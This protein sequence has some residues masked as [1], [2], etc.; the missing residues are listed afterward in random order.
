M[1]LCGLG[2]QSRA[3]ALRVRRIGR[4]AGAG[5]AIQFQPRNRRL[6]RSIGQASHRPGNIHAALAVG[7]QV[8]DSLHGFGG[9]AVCL[10]GWGGRGGLA[11]AIP[12]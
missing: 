6:L 5:E 2:Q 10:G 7:A 9:G 8:H 1:P 3:R 11:C 12:I 4:V